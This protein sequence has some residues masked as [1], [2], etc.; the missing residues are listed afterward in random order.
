MDWVLLEMGEGDEFIMT[1]RF[2]DLSDGKIE[3]P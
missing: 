2:F 1:L 3:F